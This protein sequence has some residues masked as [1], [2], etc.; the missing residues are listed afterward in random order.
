M[1][2][3]LMVDSNEETNEQVWTDF[4]INKEKID[5]FFPAYLKEGEDPSLNVF[6]NGYQIT[7]KTEKHLTDYL[8]SRKDLMK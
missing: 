3:K 2:V 1:I 5:A 4:H 8:M 7:L 6:F